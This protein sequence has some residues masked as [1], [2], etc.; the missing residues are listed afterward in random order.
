MNKNEVGQSFLRPPQFGLNDVLFP[1]LGAAKINEDGTE[2]KTGS[3]VII[4]ACWNTM[5]GSAMVS[6]PWSF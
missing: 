6:L 1:I 5:V 2:A 4:F 3:A